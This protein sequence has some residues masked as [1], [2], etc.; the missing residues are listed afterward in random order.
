MRIL[1]YK[2]VR[3]TNIFYELILHF[4]FS[5]YKYDES[6]MNE[7]N[8]E[9]IPRTIILEDRSSFEYWREYRGQFARF[10]SQMDL[11][12]EI[13]DGYKSPEKGNC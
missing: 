6:S 2:N 8:L 4:M 10:L 11:C 5:L 1:E 12:E 7:K 9:K 3:I 13:I